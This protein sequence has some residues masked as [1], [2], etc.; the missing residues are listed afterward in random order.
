LAPRTDLQTSWDLKGNFE[1][2]A[3][4]S[5]KRSLNDVSPNSRTTQP[6]FK[7]PTQYFN[8]PFPF[9]IRIPGLTVN[10]I[11]NWICKNKGIRFLQIRS[12]R[13]RNAS[14]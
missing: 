14:K 4:V 1:R 7:S 11:F 6:R 13:R 12:K 3:R 5:L 8:F 2:K 10:G 9:P